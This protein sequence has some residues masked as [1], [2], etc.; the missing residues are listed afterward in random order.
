VV[1]LAR[2]VCFFV[3][4]ILCWA[5][6]FR[7]FLAFILR[8]VFSNCSR[9]S[10]LQIGVCHLAVRRNVCRVEFTAQVLFGELLKDIVAMARAEEQWCRWM[11]TTCGWG[12]S[13]HGPILTAFGGTVPPCVAHLRDRRPCW[14]KFRSS[15]TTRAHFMAAP[16]RGHTNLASMIEES[17]FR[18][19]LAK[20]GT[21][22]AKITREPWRLAGGWSA[23]EPWLEKH[24]EAIRRNVLNVDGGQNRKT[25]IYFRENYHPLEWFEAS[26]S[27]IF[28]LAPNSPFLFQL[29]RDSDEV[30]V[31]LGFQ[32]AGRPVLTAGLRRRAGGSRPALQWWWVH[33]RRGRWRGGGGRR[34]SQNQ[35]G[36]VGGGR[37]RQSPS[38]PAPEGWQRGW[39]E[40]GGRASTKAEAPAAEEPAQS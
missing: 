26:P 22:T 34:S 8:W 18:L 24:S 31:W 12:R 32:V 11:Q 40:E 1:A 10:L 25:Q 21:G 23:T 20:Q 13:A 4:F 39:V 7:L 5:S 30:R 15:A 17:P 6:A 2:V 27:S 19:A 35:G 16:F 36:G 33:G 9:V 29:Q 14:S 38:S 3:A 28:L 37:G